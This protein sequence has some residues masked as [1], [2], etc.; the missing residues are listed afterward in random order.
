[1]VKSPALR[2]FRPQESSELA[3]LFP[4]PPRSRALYGLHQRA[5][6]KKEVVVGKRW[7]LIQRRIG[8]RFDGR[9]NGIHAL[10]I[11]SN[12]F[13]TLVLLPLSLLSV[14]PCLR[15]GCWVLSIAYFFFLPALTAL[16]FLALVAVFPGN[17]PPC[18]ST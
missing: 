12:D 13:W 7:D 16:C 4:R 14:T 15:G 9:N 2:L 17:R 6:S 5:V 8:R 1:G 3:E 10:I 11:A 18:R